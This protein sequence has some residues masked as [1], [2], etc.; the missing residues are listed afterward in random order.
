MR[1]A[2]YSNQSR[3]A[4][5]TRLY[6]EPPAR[7]PG[8]R[9]RPRQYGEKWISARLDTLSWTEVTLSLYGR[10]QVLRYRSQIAKARFLGGCLV[11]A[12]WCE[13]QG[14]KGEWQSTRLMIS[15]DTSLTAGHQSV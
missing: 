13:F 15:T 14:K 10:E 8:T 2:A 7:E 11:R 3:Y 6:D 12:V 5:D 9:G 4:I 1:S